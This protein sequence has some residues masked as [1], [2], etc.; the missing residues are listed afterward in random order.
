[1]LLINSSAI[2][3]VEASVVYHMIIEGVLAETGYH[4]FYQALQGR[5]LLPGL[6]QGLEYWCSATRRATSPLA[7]TSCSGT[8]GPIPNCGT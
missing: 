7:C 2:A 4:G 6:V 8:C 1:M 5:G 3:Q